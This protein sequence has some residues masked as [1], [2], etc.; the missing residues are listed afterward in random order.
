L[1]IEQFRDV[2]LDLV[3][4]GDDHTSRPLALLLCLKD[5][6]ATVRGLAEHMGVTKPVVTRAVDRGA[7]DLYVE[8][9]PDPADRRSV[10]VALTASGRRFVDGIAKPANGTVL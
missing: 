4:A 2:M 1:N 3:R 5:G 9:R 6:P 10:L 7:E 8:R